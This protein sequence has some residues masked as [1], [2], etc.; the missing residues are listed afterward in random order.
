MST[1]TLLYPIPT[2]FP[3]TY[4]I[5]QKFCNGAI[6]ADGIVSS[7]GFGR[8]ISITHVETNTVYRVATDGLPYSN[9]LAPQYRQLGFGQL[10]IIWN[11]VVYGDT[12]QT[13]GTLSVVIDLDT[14]FPTASQAVNPGSV[15]SNAGGSNGTGQFENADDLLDAA[16]RV[17]IDLAA[18]Q[19]LLKLQE[20]L[21]TLEFET[22]KIGLEVGQAIEVNLPKYGIAAQTMIV[23][24]IR[25]TEESKLKLLSYVRV[26]NQ[27]VQADYVAAFSKLVKRLRRPS[28]KST[29]TITF[30]LAETIQDLENTG[31]TVGTNK[32]NVVMITKDFQ[33]TE[34]AVKFKTPPTGQPIIIDILQNGVTIF[35][36]STTVQYTVAG[37]V[38]KFA[39]FRTG[40]LLLR[41]DDE[42]T[43]NVSQVG[44]PVPG[45]DGT[46]QISGV[47]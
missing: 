13:S 36:T 46:V 14:T 28:N 35:P 10:N 6:I 15:D 16:D 45:K 43:L 22:H 1:Q 34:V 37:G 31:L 44:A 5:V 47:G 19:T 32:T 41:K 8:V 2:S 25:T 27:S 18:A 7:A 42:I 33:L 39:S 17:S 11:R 4:G 20:E 38:Q 3:S 21:V 26:S 40:T 9:P 12:W 29:Q 24:S 30:V 23:E